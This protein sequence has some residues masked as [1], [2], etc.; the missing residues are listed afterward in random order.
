VKIDVDSVRE[1]RARVDGVTDELDPLEAFDAW[2]T[3]NGVVA[4]GARERME[5]D[6]EQV[7]L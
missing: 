1:Q 5:A 7:G 2:A 3:A 4:D 6:L